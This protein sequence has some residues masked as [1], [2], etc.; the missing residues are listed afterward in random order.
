[1]GIHLDESE[2]AD[3]E[4]QIHK[5]FKKELGFFDDSTFRGT[6]AT[7]HR[8]VEREELEG[9]LKD[10]LGESKKVLKLGEEVPSVKF[11]IVSPFFISGVGYSRGVLPFETRAGWGGWVGQEE[12]C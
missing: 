2:L 8:G 6:M 1:M 10:E 11:N 7:I 5:I 9:H 4:P 3:L 12:T